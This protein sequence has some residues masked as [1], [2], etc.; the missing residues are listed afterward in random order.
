MTFPDANDRPILGHAGASEYL[1]VRHGII[2]SAATF[3]KYACLG[4]PGGIERPKIRKAGRDVLY[5][6]ADL[7]EFASR[8][9]REP[10]S[11][12]KAA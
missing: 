11:C 3:A 9:I 10:E 5:L 8:L 7:D 12:G 1:R 6:P 2:R 4:C